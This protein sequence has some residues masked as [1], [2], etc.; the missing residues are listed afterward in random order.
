MCS[1]VGTE[2]LWPLLI[3][4][5][6]GPAL[7]SLVILPLLPE[8]PRYLLLVRQNREAARKGPSTLTRHVVVIVNARLL[9]NP[10]QL[11][12]TGVCGSTDT[13]TLNKFYL[14][15]VFRKKTPTFVF[16]HNS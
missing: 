9:L 12:Y 14:Y 15:T 7:V 2:D 3:L 8:T 13:E 1:L 4:V 10:H 16:F 11:H 5:E 6:V